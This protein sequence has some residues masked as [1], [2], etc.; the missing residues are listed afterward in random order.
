MYKNALNSIISMRNL[1]REKQKEKEDK[2]MIGVTFSPK[3]NRKSHSKTKLINED[4]P[5]RVGERLYSFLKTNQE[6]LDIS[7]NAK[8]NKIM[9]K[10]T[11]QPHI[12]PKYINL[13]LT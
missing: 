2:E 9:S 6:K 11:F 8:Y 7:K 12:E 5:K 3:I 13:L 10:C 1:A 4:S